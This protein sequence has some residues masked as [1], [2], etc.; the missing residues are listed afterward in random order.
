MPSYREHHKGSYCTIL[1]SEE[2][3]DISMDAPAKDR[4]RTINILKEFA[5]NGMENLT[6]QQMVIE[7]QFPAGGNPPRMITVYA[8]KSYQLRTY[9]AVIENNGRRFLCVESTLKKTQKADQA[10]LRRVARKIGK[11][12]K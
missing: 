2:A 5:E 9:G 8:V 4:K 10:Q 12:T 1:V 7:G 6:K 11:E 3:N